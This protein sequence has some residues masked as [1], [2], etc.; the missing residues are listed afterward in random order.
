METG[1]WDCLLG[2]EGGGITLLSAIGG[3]PLLTDPP[4]VRPVKW[5]GGIVESLLLLG[6]LSFLSATL[7]DGPFELLPIDLT[8]A[9]G[10]A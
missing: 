6:P 4:M 9:F 5:L 8:L 3:T 2:L 10:S 7:K 1:G